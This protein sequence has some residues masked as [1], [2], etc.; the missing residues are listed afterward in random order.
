MCRAFD[1]HDCSVGE[2]SGQLLQHSGEGRLIQW[3]GRIQ[4]H[5]IPPDFSLC[6]FKKRLNL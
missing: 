4:E 1:H 5:Q 3:I 2:M 6:P